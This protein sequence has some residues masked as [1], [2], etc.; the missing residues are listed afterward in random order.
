MVGLRGHVL[1]PVTSYLAWRVG[2]NFTTT[3]HLTRDN[4]WT[5]CGK[6]PDGLLSVWR[7]KKPPPVEDQCSSCRKRDSRELR[8]R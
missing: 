1:M 2:R 4:R 8:N 5:L 3:W 6:R 7:D